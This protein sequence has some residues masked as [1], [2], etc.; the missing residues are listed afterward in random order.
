MRESGSRASESTAGAAR[1]LSARPIASIAGARSV[2]RNACVLGVVL[3]LGTALAAPSPARS[4]CSRSS[5]PERRARLLELY[6]S[7]GCS[8]CPPADRWLRL[9]ALQPATHRLVPLSL[10]VTY[11]D[12]IGWKDPYADPAF[13]AR[14]RWLAALNR[15]RTV[16]TPAVYLD[17][18]EWRDW[19][20]TLAQRSRLR[21][22]GA[23]APGADISIDVM[24]D[25]DAPPGS[26]LVRIAATVRD[27]VPAGARVALFVAST[28]SRLQNDVTAGENSGAR[29]QHDHVVRRWSGP[30]RMPP[31]GTRSREAT[32]AL[33]ASQ[34]DPDRVAIAAFVQDLDSGAILQA[35]RVPLSACRGPVSS[36]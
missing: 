5:D 35:M 3:V 2:R 20:S 15:S 22:G 31:F 8:S 16:Y 30:H 25:D 21:D 17:G 12:Y 32:L 26:R 33:D 23:P 27:A 36:G 14:Q 1:W 6:T 29:L 10:H 7:Q 11:W 13:V 18:V 19:S 24:H 28:E 9:I 34:A 4:A